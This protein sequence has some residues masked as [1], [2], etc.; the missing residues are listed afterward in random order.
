ME[1]LQALQVLL[2]HFF[3]SDFQSNRL[4]FNLKRPM[5]Q[6]HLPDPT[7]WSNTRPFGTDFF[8]FFYIL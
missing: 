4:F 5:S 2:W 3:A 8:F 1:A 6:S 7:F